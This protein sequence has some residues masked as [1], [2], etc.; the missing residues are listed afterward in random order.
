MI[1]YDDRKTAGHF[2]G[3]RYTG[4]KMYL[5]ASDREGCRS[6]HVQMILNEREEQR[7]CQQ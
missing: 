1:Q 2:R 7:R 5:G 4:E 6:G 3:I